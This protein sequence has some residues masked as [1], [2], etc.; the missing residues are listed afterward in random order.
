[1][2]KLADT[3]NLLLT[4]PY[5]CSLKKWRDYTRNYLKGKENEEGVIACEC[6]RLGYPKCGYA[7]RAEAMRVLHTPIV[8][9]A[10]VKECYT[11]IKKN[12]RI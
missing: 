11:N 9:M 3:Y 4:K 5:G 12:S 2:G 8:T 7:R 6:Y 10:L 1:M